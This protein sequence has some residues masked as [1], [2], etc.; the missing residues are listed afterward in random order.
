M[1]VE[2][3]YYKSIQKEIDDYKK[4]YSKI[5]LAYE[6]SSV[7]S[8]EKFAGSIAEILRGRS[9]QFI[10]EVSLMPL[11]ERESDM[12]NKV[13]HALL[14]YYKGDLLSFIREQNEKI[15]ELYQKSVQ[16]C[17]ARKQD[18]YSWDD[19]KKIFIKESLSN[20]KCD[21]VIM[22]I[23]QL[24]EVLMKQYN[25]IVYDKFYHPIEKQVKKLTIIE[26][27]KTKRYL[28]NFIKTNLEGVKINVN[29]LSISARFRKYFVCVR[30]AIIVLIILMVLISI[31]YIVYFANPSFA[32]EHYPTWLLNIIL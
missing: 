30:A 13:H 27:M 32:N 25:E 9:E 11:E 22:G 28:T 3:L 6:E 16:M 17:G 1:S 4:E 10:K 19:E 7:E 29:D 8:I 5:N 18:L 15:N 12:F 21:D 23:H 14:S 26:A 20:E 31:I 2:D 24:I